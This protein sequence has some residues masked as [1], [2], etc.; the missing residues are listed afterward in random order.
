MLKVTSRAVAV[1]KAAKFAEGASGDAGIRLRQGNVGNEGA[2]AVGF[3][4]STEPVPTDDSFE[5]DGLRIFVED[6][7]TEPLDGRTLD[8]SD[9]TEGVQ[10]IFR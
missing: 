7:L 4:I 10:L 9:E 3:A 8:L 2:I 1:L 6:K 5:Q